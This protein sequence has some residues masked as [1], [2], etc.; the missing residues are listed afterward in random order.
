[1]TDQ[2]ALT[3]AVLNAYNA[4]DDGNHAEL[5]L[6]GLIVVEV[7]STG[8]V[9]SDLVTIAIGD[10]ASWQVLGMLHGARLIGERLFNEDDGQ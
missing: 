5:I 7:L 8:K 4:D 1:M 2:D 10:P 3:V 9:E 6:H